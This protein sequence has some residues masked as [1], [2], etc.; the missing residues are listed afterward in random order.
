MLY[1]PRTNGKAERFIQTTS[2]ENGP[3]KQAYAYS[4]ERK[5]AILFWLH[6][7]NHRRPSYAP[8]EQ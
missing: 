2:S 5:A 3:Y 4:A 7:Y 8:P 1:T 6:N